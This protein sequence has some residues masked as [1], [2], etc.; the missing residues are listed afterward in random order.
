MNNLRQ[1]LNASVDLPTAEVVNDSKSNYATH[2]DN[3]VSLSKDSKDTRSVGGYRLSIAAIDS[4]SG[5][6][7][8]EIDTGVSYQILFVNG[9]QKAVA[10]PN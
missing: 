5:I 8:E 10:I 1:Q 3:M 4:L 6:S 7:E 2:F 9:V